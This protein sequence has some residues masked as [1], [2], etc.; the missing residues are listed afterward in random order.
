MKSSNLAG[1]AWAENW[2]TTP[3]GF[4]EQNQLCC[5]RPRSVTWFAVLADH[6][7]RITNH[8]PFSGVHEQ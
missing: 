5:L 7:S 6:E 1:E 3:E 8:G 4:A 2:H